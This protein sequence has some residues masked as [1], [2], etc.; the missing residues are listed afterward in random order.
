MWNADTIFSALIQRADGNAAVLGNKSDELLSNVLYVVV[1]SQLAN[2]RLDCVLG[3]LTGLCEKTSI[4][5]SMPSYLS[6]DS[7]FSI[8]LVA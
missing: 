8:S 2:V 6:C 7:T 3:R 5:K 1:L 4:D